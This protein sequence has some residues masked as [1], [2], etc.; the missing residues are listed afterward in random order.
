MEPKQSDKEVAIFF[1][2][3]KFVIRVL[4]RL[5]EVAN[6]ETIYHHELLEYSF[7]KKIMENFKKVGVACTRLF[8]VQ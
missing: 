2:A 5:V 6:V 7:S 4:I 1:S 8:P 3:Q